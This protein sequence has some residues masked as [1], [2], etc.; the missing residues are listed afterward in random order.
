MPIKDNIARVNEFILNNSSVCEN[1]K[2]EIRN[3]L[4]DHSTNFNSKS[5]STTEQHPKAL[6]PLISPLKWVNR[7]SLKH[8]EDNKQ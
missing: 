8:C 3:F 7:F 4:I 5:I 2:T 1:I 6:A